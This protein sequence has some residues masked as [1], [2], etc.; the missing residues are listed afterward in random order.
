[1]V[2]TE[3]FE[4]VGTTEA[5]LSFTSTFRLTSLVM[6]D[7]A[8]RI[9]ALQCK[10]LRRKSELLAAPVRS[11]IR[12]ERNRLCHTHLLLHMHEIYRRISG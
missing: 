4:H 8:L 5:S 10:V 12:T 11:D 6:S 2:V 7:T 3:A 9:V 1:M